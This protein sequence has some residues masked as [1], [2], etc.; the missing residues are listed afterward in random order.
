MCSVPPGP[1]PADSTTNFAHSNLRMGNSHCLCRSIVQSPRRWDPL[2]L[3]SRW[4]AQLS[5][6]HSNRSNAV[7]SS[8]LH[9]IPLTDAAASLSS[10]TKDARSWPVPFPSGSVLTRRLKP[11]PQ[12]SIGNNCAKIC[13]QSLNDLSSI[14]RIGGSACESNTPLPVRTTAGFEDREDHRIPSASSFVISRAAVD[15][16]V[17]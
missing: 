17:C 9:R 6:L 5:P 14:S 16:E 13:A 3:C 10:P 7:V 1:L 2:L 4:I 12:P 11:Q 8:R 15:S